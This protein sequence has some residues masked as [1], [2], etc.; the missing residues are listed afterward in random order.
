VRSLYKVDGLGIALLRFDD[1]VVV[2]V[3]GTEDGAKDLAGHL[4]E[5]VST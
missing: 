5:A 1:L 2:A 3:T 4:S